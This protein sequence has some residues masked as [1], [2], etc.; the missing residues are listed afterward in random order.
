MTRKNEMLYVDIP[1]LTQS[2]IEEAKK[3]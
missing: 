1:C 2:V 3:S